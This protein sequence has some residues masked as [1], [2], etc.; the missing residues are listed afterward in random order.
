MAGNGLLTNRQYI[1]LSHAI[2]GPNMESIAQGYMD[3]DMDIICSIRY[4]NM[5][6]V[7]QG[8]KAMIQKWANQP[9]NSNP[10]Q[11]RVSASLF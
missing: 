9:K 11:T 2:S 3:L 7:A 6:N 5:G 1:L 10:N 8:N 4:Q